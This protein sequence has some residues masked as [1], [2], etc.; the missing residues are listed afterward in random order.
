MGQAR[1][2]PKHEG[3]VMPEAYRA[4]EVILGMPWDSNIDMWNV[5]LLVRRLLFL[6]RAPWM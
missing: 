1:I 6:P 2:G 5:G 4:P 3:I